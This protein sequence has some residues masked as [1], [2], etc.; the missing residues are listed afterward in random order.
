MDKMY[1]VEDDRS[2]G[3]Y[4]S[5]HG[6]HYS[7]AH[8]HRLYDFGRAAAN[9]I[10]ELTDGRNN[11]AVLIYTGMS[12]ISAATAIACA[13]L[14][15]HRKPSRMCYVRKLN[16]S[17]HGLHVETEDAPWS[18][19]SMAIFVDDFVSSGRTLSHMVSTLSEWN[20]RVPTR[21]ILFTQKFSDGY[22]VRESTRFY[23][24][25]SYNPSAK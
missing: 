2:N 14:A 7:L 9:K 24:W 21:R 4:V 6:S 12:G 19:L 8:D 17:S 20:Y 18:T 11:D 22:A 15:R 16:E 5:T 1:R 23:E 3:V 10:Y 13:Q 25:Y